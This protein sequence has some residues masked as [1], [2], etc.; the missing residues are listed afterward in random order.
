M[1]KIAICRKLPK[2]KIFK[3]KLKLDNQ[4]TIPIKPKAATEADAYENTDTNVI[5]FA[6]V[7]NFIHVYL[8]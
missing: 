6:W 4:V 2:Q 1:T 5:V 7:Y 3:Q 8:M